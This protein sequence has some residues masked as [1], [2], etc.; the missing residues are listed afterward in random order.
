MS[1]QIRQSR[2]AE[3]RIVGMIT[4]QEPCMPTSWVYPQYSE[5][6]GAH[7]AFKSKFSSKE[8]SDT[9]K[10]RAVSDKNVRLK[11]LPVNAKLD[12]AALKDLIGKTQ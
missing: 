12:N 9:A 5:S 8:I 1:K 4:K 11:R 7:H 6:Q 2:F 3:A 10:L